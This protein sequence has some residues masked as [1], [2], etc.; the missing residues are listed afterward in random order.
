MHNLILESITESACGVCSS[1]LQM[2]FPL[3][4]CFS[5]WCIPEFGPSRDKRRERKWI[6]MSKNRI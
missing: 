5:S 2:D 3:V 1:D 6:R 4:A